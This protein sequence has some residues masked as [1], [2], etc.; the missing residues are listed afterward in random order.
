[1]EW[2]VLAP[3]ALGCALIVIDFAR[4]R[5]RTSVRPPEPP[6]L[7]RGAMARKPHSSVPG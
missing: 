4:G 2:L 1:M 5:A 6:S 3:V 7:D